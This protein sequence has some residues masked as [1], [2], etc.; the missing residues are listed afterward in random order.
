MIEQSQQ[1]V[2]DREVGLEKYN[3]S[4]QGMVDIDVSRINRRKVF[5]SA[6]ST[7]E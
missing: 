5:V 1:Q 7:R 2:I 6:V 4:Q 3:S